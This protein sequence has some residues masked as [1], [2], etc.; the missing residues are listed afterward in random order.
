V[1]P[2]AGQKAPILYTFVVIN[3]L[4]Q[5]WF[6]EGKELVQLL[7]EKFE[8]IKYKCNKAHFSLENW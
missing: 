1:V 3:Y 5:Q 7:T 4:T 2:T 6:Q 8:V